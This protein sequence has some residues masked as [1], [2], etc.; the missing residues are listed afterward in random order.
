VIRR[1]LRGLLSIGLFLCSL[2]SPRDD[3]LWAF[4][5]N[6]GDAF[7]DNAKYL[8]LHTAD[9]RDHVRAVWLTRNESVVTALRDR[10]YE[11]YHVDSPKGI[12]LNLRA[13]TVFV[14]HGMPDVN[15][16]CSGGAT[17]VLLWHGV[18]LKRIGWDA[19]KLRHRRERLKRVVKDTLF[20]RYDWITVPS[21]AMVGPF[22]SAFRIEDDRVLA[23]GY[24]RNDVPAGTWTGED[25]MRE[26]DLERRYRGYREEGP[27]ILYV[28]TIHRE[29]GERVVDHLDL[30]R[31]D[32]WLAERDARLLFK[33]HPAE[34]IDLE[35]EFDRIVEVPSEV[36]IYPLLAHTDL[37]LTDY[38]S[39]YF[40]YLHL[41]RPVAFYPFD[42]EAY[43]TERGFYLGYDEVTPGPVATE[44]D[45]LLDCLDGTLESDEYAPE[46]AAVR[47]EFVETAIESRCREV[48][49]RFDPRAGRRGRREE[50]PARS[51]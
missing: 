47:E 8:Y 19:P 11:A 25:P 44:F 26:D 10:G 2:V 1:G 7:R 32:E 14:T 21:E 35:E 22:A 49:D 46:R 33:P 31:L 41:D 29:T 15:R 9:R 18:A 6:G 20:D 43:R 3:S 42:Y 37:L 34:P 45:D 36:D 5:S 24:P 50:R 48:G 16:W 40:D 13:G 30:D 17:T 28:P 23:T 38:S 4:G 27:V 51:V 12:W 39:I